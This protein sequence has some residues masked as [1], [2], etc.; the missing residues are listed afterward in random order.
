MKPKEG[1]V[2][3]ESADDTKLRYEREK[4]AAELALRRE[5][6]DLK[7]A[8]SARQS[9]FWN[10]VSPVA[11]ALFAGFLGLAGNLVVTFIQGRNSA[12]V[13][14]RKSQ[15]AMIAEAIKTGDEGRA[16]RN[17]LFF[18]DTGL[19]PDPGGKIRTA[20]QQL[21]GIPVLP[22]PSARGA[23]FLPA[24]LLDPSSMLA[25]YRQAVGRLDVVV[26][27]GDGNSCTALAVSSR[28]IIT[29]SYCIANAKTAFF[30]PAIFGNA[31]DKASRPISV[32]LPPLHISQSVGNN[33]ASVAAMVVESGVSVS[34]RELKIREPKND[35][36]IYILQ[37]IGTDELQVS[38]RDC[39]VQLQ[40]T[41]PPNGVFTYYCHTAPGS[42][43]SP[44]FA[45]A[46]G[47]LLGIHLLVT[48][49]FAVVPSQL[50]R[51]RLAS[52]G[53]VACLSCGARFGPEEGAQP[54]KAK[55]AVAA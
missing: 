23:E 55:R 8:E 44:V 12:D 16:K 1:K 37:Y 26:D 29:A 41:A 32:N 3:N 45:V 6:L 30:S 22:S 40:E 7:K 54:L 43:G 2:A 52:C 11:I 47:A 36:A 4:F 38:Y 24:R 33:N 27:S 51:T 31:E 15:A 50:R 21:G 48:R 35:E 18:L 14:S 42:A 46:D 13:E 10:Q 28:M 53:G 25:T 39:T 17:V 49:A 20:L 34:P 5:E 19:I 9:R